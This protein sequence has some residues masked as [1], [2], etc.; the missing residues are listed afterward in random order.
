[1][2]WAEFYQICFFVGCLLSFVL[3]FGGLHLHLPFQF[4]LPHF[5][6]GGAH[7][8]APAAHA[9]PFNPFSLA[10]FLAWFGGAGFLLTRYQPLW[11]WTSFLLA[12]AVGWV[13]GGIVFWFFAKL[14][15]SPGESLDPADY[16]MPG[17][18][19][20]VSMTIREGGTGE[21]IFVQKGSRKCC[22]ARNE[23]GS[24]IAKGEEVVVT[25]YERGI[26]YVRRWEE[27]AGENTSDTTVSHLS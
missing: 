15:T 9:S 24:A 4:K 20:R 6:G 3:F 2:T 21:V 17:V 19:G 16:E 23:N 7:S 14:M 12:A 26:A 1:M 11:A 22:G 27:L 13:G 10:V 5:G 25:R 8:G 18:L